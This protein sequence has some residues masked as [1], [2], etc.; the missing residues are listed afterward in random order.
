[1]PLSLQ[2]SLFDDR[3]VASRPLRLVRAG[4]RWRTGAGNVGAMTPPAPQP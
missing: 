4:H 3:A 1:M 2:L